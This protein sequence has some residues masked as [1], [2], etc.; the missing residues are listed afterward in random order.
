M[1]MPK[2]FMDILTDASGFTDA[3]SEY[4]GAWVTL[5]LSNGA[6]ITGLAQYVERDE[7][8]QIARQTSHRVPAEF[9][10]TPHFV[11]PDQIIMINFAEAGA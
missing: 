1:S 9:A 10:D 4:E 6:Q 2:V 8:V 11:R 5:H 7:F 3:D